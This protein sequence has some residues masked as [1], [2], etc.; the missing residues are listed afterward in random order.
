MTDYSK[1]SLVPPVGDS[2]YQPLEEGNYPGTLVRIIY[3][4][5]LPGSEQYPTP[6]LKVRF[7]WELVTGEIVGQEYTYSLNE[8]ANLFNLIK[9]WTKKEPTEEFN[10]ASL[11]LMKGEV[12]VGQKTSAKGSK[13]N[14]V[15]LVYPSDH[16]QTLKTSSYIWTV[17]DPDLQIFASFPDFIQKKI[18]SSSEYKGAPFAET[19]ATATDVKEMNVVT[20]TSPAPAEKPSDDSVDEFFK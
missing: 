12:M 16:D 2:D 20:K 6:K 5:E 3:M 19:A 14:I 11:Y 18:R 13:Y 4:G 9:V 15:S 17:Q 8:Q 7:E 10:L 1:M